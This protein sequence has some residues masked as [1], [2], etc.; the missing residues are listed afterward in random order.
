V[1]TEGGTGSYLS[2]AARAVPASL[3]ADEAILSG[4]NCLGNTGNPPHGLSPPQTLALIMELGIIGRIADFHTLDKSVP[5]L[6]DV[7]NR[8]LR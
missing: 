1:H 3:L 8:S 2:I 4:Y 6:V 7:L 5:D